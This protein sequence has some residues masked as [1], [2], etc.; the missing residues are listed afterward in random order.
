MCKVSTGQRLMVW[1]NRMQTAQYSKCRL[2]CS[3][4]VPVPEPVPPS[5]GSSSLCMTVPSELGPP[6][7]W[8]GLLCHWRVSAVPGNVL[9][10]PALCEIGCLA[11]KEKHLLSLSTWTQPLVMGAG[12]DHASPPTPALGCCGTLLDWAGHWDGQGLFLNWRDH[13]GQLSPSPPPTRHGGQWLLGKL[14]PVSCD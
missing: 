8:Q 2:L 1:S 13:D 9:F 11:A 12:A 3:Q 5:F 6:C 4:E 10:H 7:W 14:V